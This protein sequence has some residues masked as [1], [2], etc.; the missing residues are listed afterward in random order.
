MINRWQKNALEG[1]LTFEVLCSTWLK[2][3]VATPLLGQHTAEQ[4]HGLSEYQI[5]GLANGFTRDQVTA[6]GFTR[7]HVEA[8]RTAPEFRSILE[9][10]LVRRF[11][12]EEWRTL[13]AT[14]IVGKS[15]LLHRAIAGNHF[16]LMLAMLEMGQYTQEQLRALIARPAAVNAVMAGNLA[17]ISTVRDIC[18]AEQWKRY[19]DEPL[20][21]DAANM[22]GL[23]CL[24]IALYQR[25][26]SVVKM[27][28][29]EFSP[30]EWIVRITTP[31][32]R[33]YAGL[34]LK[35]GVTP[36]YYAAPSGPMVAA[37]LKGYT[38]QQWRQS[39]NMPLTQAQG[40]DKGATPVSIADFYSADDAV[41]T[42]REGGGYS[43]EEW[44]KLPKGRKWNIPFLIG[45]G[46]PGLSKNA[47]AE[48]SSAVS[49][50]VENTATL[51]SSHSTSSGKR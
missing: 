18:G 21:S 20:P 5:K 51:A 43:Q 11:S 4:L 9:D 31:I 26:V 48:G 14:P 2:E 37:L 13:L 28:R 3:E 40:P 35:A 1:G 41:K 6:P 24:W 8:R 39:I 36:L 32:S 47:I 15:S 33:D 7:M 50:S 12:A 49:E 45:F 44:N 16:D 22:E 19:I 23:N 27:L 10:A 29:E 42:M 30:G 25:K 46:W 34:R 38:K 17:M